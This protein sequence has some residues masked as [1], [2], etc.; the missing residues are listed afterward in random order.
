MAINDGPTSCD[1]KI[2]PGKEPK[3]IDITLHLNRGDVTVLGI[4]EIK[5]DTLKVCYFHSKTGKRPADF[6]T[7]DDPNVAHIVLTRAKK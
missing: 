2:D 5:G 4:Y 7:K 3:Q 6:S 1:F